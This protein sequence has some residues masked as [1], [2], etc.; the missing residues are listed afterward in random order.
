MKTKRM[1]AEIFKSDYMVAHFKIICLPTIGLIILKRLLGRL[2]T[3][4][5]DVIIFFKN[6]FL[7]IL[8]TTYL[9]KWTAQPL[10]L[11]TAGKGKLALSLSNKLFPNNFFNS[12]LRW[13]YLHWKSHRAILIIWKTEIFWRLKTWF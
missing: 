6:C 3:F 4:L 11:N 8:L 9:L 1:K 2:R 12:I 13:N 7:S 10:A 5:H